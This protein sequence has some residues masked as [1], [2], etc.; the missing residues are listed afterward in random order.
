MGMDDIRELPQWRYI[1]VD[2][3]DTI[4]DDQCPRLGPTTQRSSNGLDLAVRD[5]DHPCPRQPAGIDQR[6]VVA[7]VG[8]HQRARSGQ[9]RDRAEVGQVAGGEDECCRH[10][11]EVGELS[12]Q[13]S[14]DIRGPGDE[15]RSGRASA[16]VAR[17]TYGTGLDLGVSGQAEVVVAGQ[18]EQPVPA[19]VPRPKAT[20]QAQRVAGGGFVGKPRLGGLDLPRPVVVLQVSQQIL[21]GGEK[22]TAQ[23]YVAVEV[24]LVVARRQSADAEQQLQVKR[25]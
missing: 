25:P 7:R 21:E 12:L 8:D 3:E 22:R 9:G 20:T 19:R 17:G 23:R 11:D 4:G 5:D 16:V 13:A 15:S 24:R 14:V 18:V 10:P 1:S 2:R 6:R